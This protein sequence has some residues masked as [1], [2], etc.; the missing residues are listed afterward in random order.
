MDD[1]G[2]DIQRFHCSGVL[3]FFL[4]VCLPVLT[5]VQV[6]VALADVEIKNAD[7]V[8]LLHLR[9]KLSQFDMLRDGLGNAE[10]DAL[11]IVYLARVLLQLKLTFYSPNR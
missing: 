10:K 6:I 3:Y 2:G 5:V 7:G 4:P 1:L 11:Q 8:H 9:V